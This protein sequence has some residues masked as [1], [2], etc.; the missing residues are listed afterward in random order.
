MTRK[1]V[2]HDAGA[3][4]C[5]DCRVVARSCGALY[6]ACTWSHARIQAERAGHTAQNH[7]RRQLRTWN[8]WNVK[9]V[10]RVSAMTE[11]LVDMC[12][13]V[14]LGVHAGSC[15]A[16][17]NSSPFKAAVSDLF[18][19]SIGLVVVPPEHLQ[20]VAS[21]NMAGRWQS[22]SAVGALDARSLVPCRF[23]EAAIEL[24]AREP[25]TSTAPLG[26][27]DSSLCVKRQANEDLDSSRAGLRFEQ[28]LMLAPS[29]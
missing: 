17:E 26:N 22:R 23:P 1:R 5:H 8:F 15:G 24:Q 12:V 11:R 6:R 18:P 25:V 10:S 16:F 20:S 2:T 27:V 28:T 9:A 19:Q 3:L 29:P 13:W 4:R 7:R 14:C 21:H